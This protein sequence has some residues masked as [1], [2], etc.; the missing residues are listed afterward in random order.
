MLRRAPAPPSPLPLYEQAR[1]ALVRDLLAKL[2]LPG[3]MLPSEPELAK[4]Y[5]VSP[6]T[7]RKTLNGLAGD[8]LVTRRQ[9]LGTF[10]ADHGK[11]AGSSRFQRLEP[12]DGVP[13]E[14]IV[15]VTARESRPVPPEAAAALG[16]A[17]AEPGIALDCLTQLGAK[18]ALAETIVLPAY[19]F[20][21]LSLA[22]GAVLT[23]ELYAVYQTEVGVMVAEM[24]ESVS[25]GPAG[26]AGASL[27]LGPKAPVL[28]IERVARGLDGRPIEWRRGIANPALLRYRG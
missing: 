5:G 8:G 11:S 9:G 19:P 1:E 7:M 16:L 22:S 28:L 26:A 27:G 4:R 20:A 15:R 24:D 18:P 14:S 17:P 10:V 23:R 2:W 3:D 12:A 6:G 13:R 25:A 21:R